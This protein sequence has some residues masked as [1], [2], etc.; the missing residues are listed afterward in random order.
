MFRRRDNTRRTPADL[1]AA[2]VFLHRWIGLTAGLV[3][4]I[5]GLSGSVLAYAQPIRNFFHPELAGPPPQDWLQQRAEVL[6]GFSADTTIRTIRFP[7]EELGVYEIHHHDERVSYRDALNGELVLDGSAIIAVIVFLRDLHIHLLAGETGEQVMG[8]IG[9]MLLALLLT[10]IWTWWPRASGWRFVFRYP[11]SGRLL[12]QLYWWHKSAGIVVLPLL[13]FVTLTGVG[14]VFYAIAQSL[15]T[16]LFGGEPLAVPGTHQAASDAYDWAAIVQSLDHT[17]PDGR[18]VYLYLPATAEATVRFRK[19]LP[20]E[21]HPNGRSF[22]A[23]T[24]G[25]EILH[26]NDAT[27]LAA[28]MRAT[29]AIY[30]LHSGKAGS[31]TWRFAVFLAGLFPAIFFI[32]GFILWRKKTSRNSSPA[33]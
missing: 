30:P 5:A 1:R 13:F 20:D 3:F 7:S 26:A 27:T 29:H 24:R 31:E 9:V 4:V 15:L 32:T 2:G 22:I 14:M 18:T 25:G 17:L 16:S 23:M 11:K 6:E 28:G 21:L 33:S 8:W 19:K 12:P 10:G